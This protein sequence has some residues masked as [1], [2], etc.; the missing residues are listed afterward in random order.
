MLST[1][2]KSMEQEYAL[3]RAYFDDDLISG[4]V[5]STIRVHY[6]HL[7]NFLIALCITAHVGNKGKQNPQLTL[8][9]DFRNCHSRN[10][11]N[12]MSIFELVEGQMNE[13]S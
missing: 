10:L 12:L 6:H 13:L 4:A 2:A 5:C 7:G 9:I 11:K 8:T 3:A 1:M